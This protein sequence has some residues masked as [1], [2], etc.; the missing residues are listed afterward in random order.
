MRNWLVNIRKR[1]NLTQLQVA[2]RVGIAQ[3][4]YNR[5]ETGKSNPSVDTAKK[6]AAVLGFNWTRFFDDRKD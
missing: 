5:I 1:Y 3:P 6:I 4:V 2:Q